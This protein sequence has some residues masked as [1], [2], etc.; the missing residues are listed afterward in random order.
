MDARKLGGL[1]KPKTKWDKVLHS[2]MLYQ[3]KTTSIV[4]L[5]IDELNPPIFNQKAEIVRMA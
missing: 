3:D 5:N 2:Y 1:G 4:K